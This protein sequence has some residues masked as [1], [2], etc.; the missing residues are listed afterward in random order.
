MPSLEPIKG[1]ISVLGFKVTSYYSNKNQS[2]FSQFPIPDNSGI[3]VHFHLPTPAHSII[4][5][6]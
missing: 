2:Y 1:K 4:N 5:R 6:L 3:D